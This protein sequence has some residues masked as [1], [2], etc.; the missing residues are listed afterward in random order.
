MKQ[1]ELHGTPIGE[2]ILSRR[3][4]SFWFPI[5]AALT[6]IGSFV[7]I[8]PEMPRAGLDP[9]WMMSM[10][11]AVAQHMRIGHDIV[12][13]FGPYAA[14]Y[15]LYYHP[16]L[17]YLML[18]TGFLFAASYLAAV[19]YVADEKRPAA[20]WIL[21]V[22]LGWFMQSRDALLFSYPLLL[23]V[24]AVKFCAEKRE[25]EGPDARQLLLATALC[26]P[27]G[28]LPLIKGNMIALCGVM[29]FFSA[30][31]LLYQRQRRLAVV[32]LITPLA[33]VLSFWALAGQP[34]SGLADYARSS[35]Q[36]LSGYTEAMAVRIEFHGV[37]GYLPDVEIAAYLVAA[38]AVL[39]NLMRGK[40]F[41]SAVKVYLGLCF[42]FFLFVGFKSGFVRHDGH[43]ELATNCLMFA[44]LFIGL[45]RWDRRTK[46]TTLLCALL[47]VGITLRYNPSVI[48]LAKAKIPY[49]RAPSA[50]PGKGLPHAEESVAKSESF[51]HFVREGLSGV[52]GRLVNGPRM[53]LFHGGGLEK[54]YR[55]SLAEIRSEY[56]FPELPGTFDIYPTEQAYILASDDAWD[57]RPV[58]QSYAA[59]EPKLESLNEQHLRTWTAPDHVL[60]QIAPNDEH[61]PSLEDGASWA[62]FLD[63]YT[64]TGTDWR[65][66]RLYRKK[67]VQ[68][69]SKWRVLQDGTQT[70]GNSV[71][72]PRAEG[73]LFAKVDL[74]PT[75]LGKLT[76]TVFKPTQVRILL[77]LSDG[78]KRDYRVLPKMMKAGFLLSP[79][80][81]D[82]EHF[83]QFIR[84]KGRPA[85][86][87]VVQEMVITPYHPGWRMWKDQYTL[88]LQ[89]YRGPDMT[90]GS[91]A[92]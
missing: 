44:A 46:A 54:E 45:V 30:G 91:S 57:P 36:M 5:F 19:L 43:A 84:G 40:V 27:L 6:L 3:L 17:D 7:P 23:A 85:S 14:L 24:C 25:I 71:V 82:T 62:A 16:A 79:L 64:I 86:G 37:L 9:S 20:A 58:F 39:W 72:V 35:A 92:R 29:L 34:L 41:R 51:S 42:S 66:A 13:T 73:P 56:Q 22:F 88:K 59:W 8:S 21:M 70:I 80:V 69:L 48:R 76:A 32:S 67:V 53:R 15:S 68:P 49:H 75:F 26:V 89:E 77:N 87:P 61:M 50:V 81:E 2:P 38:G 31:Y 90:D 33:A 4:R 78:T 18:L 12:F 65:F 47:F 83:A 55:E 10:N 28:L 74:E 1:A 11:Q 52:Y 63:N 60:I